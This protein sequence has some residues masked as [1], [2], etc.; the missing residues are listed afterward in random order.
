MPT[1]ACSVSPQD[2]RIVGVRHVK[3]RILK[4][5]LLKMFNEIDCVGMLDSCG[6]KNLPL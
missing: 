1:I 5:V 6:H 2:R 4:D 3:S